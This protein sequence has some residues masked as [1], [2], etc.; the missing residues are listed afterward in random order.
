MRLN[1]GAAARTA[2]NSDRDH[3]DS[4]RDLPEV[5]EIAAA[6]PKCQCNEDSGAGGGGESWCLHL[7]RVETFSVHTNKSFLV[8][9]ERLVDTN[10]STET[11]DTSRGG[12]KFR[13]PTSCGASRQQ[14]T[15]NYLN[16]ST[17]TRL[18]TL[19]N[20][21]F[22]LRNSGS[23]RALKWSCAAPAKFFLLL[24]LLVTLLVLI[25]TNDYPS[26]VTV[27]GQQ[28][29]RHLASNESSLDLPARGVDESPRAP[30]AQPQHLQS[31]LEHYQAQLLSSL[32]SL[33]LSGLQLTGSGASSQRPAQARP[34]TLALPSTMS[35][36]TRKQLVG[37]VEAEDEIIDEAQEQLQVLQRQLS[38]QVTADAADAAADAADAAAAAADASVDASQTQPQAHAEPAKQKPIQTKASSSST[39]RG[40]SARARGL[41]SLD[42]SNSLIRPQMKQIKSRFNQGCVGGTKCQFFAFCWMSG[43][44]LGASCGLLMTCCVTP[45]K[46]E[47]QPVFYGPVINDPCECPLSL[48]YS[49]VRLLTFVF[50]AASSTS[51]SNFR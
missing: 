46:A 33:R 48:A 37:R 40:L 32:A 12:R 49:A 51:A 29:R 47:I 26:S 10:S 35:L 23:T 50:R 38:A 34:S 15:S 7:R 36:H 8:K 39:A 42:S 3:E 5:S 17:I 1:S 30:L 45:S 20:S 22:L 16:S 21:S 19:S 44:S 11:G 31:H 24:A 9:C 14:Q 41:L 27:I 18:S 4:A 6:R 43:G 28:P 13:R 25:I 2:K